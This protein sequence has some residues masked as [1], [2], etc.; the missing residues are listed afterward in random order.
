MSDRCLLM[1]ES[2]CLRSLITFMGSTSRAGICVACLKLTT[3]GKRIVNRLYSGDRSIQFNFNRQKSRRNRAFY[4]HWSSP[5]F[6]TNIL[7]YRLDRHS[8]HR[9]KNLEGYGKHSCFLKSVQS[10]LSQLIT[11][12]VPRAMFTHFLVEHGLS[13]CHLY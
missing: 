9:N 12:S 2:C 1:T 4:G 13:Q 7:K 8:S 10:T 11:T 3:L 6:L 5:V